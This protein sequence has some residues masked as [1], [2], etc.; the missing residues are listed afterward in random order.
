MALN[1][2]RF[3]SES[4]TVMMTCYHSTLAL[5]I[6]PVKYLYN[7][8]K[9]FLDLGNALL[10]FARDNISTLALKQDPDDSRILASLW[11]E[12]KKRVTAFVSID[13]NTWAQHRNTI[14]DIGVSIWYPDYSGNSDI[15]SYCWQIKDNDG[16]ENRHME[17]QPDIF[18]FGRTDIVSEAQV[19]GIFDDL[20][21]FSMAGAQVVI[22]GHGV[23][24]TLGLLE[25]YWK[26]PSSAIILDTQKI[27]QIQYQ[28]SY[29]VSLE[30]AL[31]MAA[32]TTY[33]KNLLNNAGNDARYTLYLLQ[34]Q[35]R[36]THIFKHSITQ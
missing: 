12:S 26:P 31:D 21:K 7:K 11:D 5:L 1:Q 20:F 33:D 2:S 35:S 30:E 34:A 29:Q 3:K 10:R 18:T 32:I 22:V 19:A 28:Q 13:V 9:L 16:L 25:R 4:V 14:T 6:W 8:L 27:W 17:N 36:V 23:R 15:N 24:F